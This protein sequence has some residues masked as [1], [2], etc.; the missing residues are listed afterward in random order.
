V[1]GFFE[2]VPKVYKK[3]KTDHKTDTPN[4]KKDSKRWIVRAQC[5]AVM[6]WR[7]LAAWTKALK[8][9]ND[10]SELC[11]LKISQEVGFSCS[12][13]IC[14]NHL[15]VPARFYPTQKFQ[16]LKFKSGRKNP[17]QK[18][19]KNSMEHENGFHFTINHCGK[20]CTFLISS[21]TSEG[22]TYKRE[23]VKIKPPDRC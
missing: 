15:E 21:Y 11:F 4:T 22:E 20:C 5:M 3:S 17:N 7:L 19:I 6:C 14:P 13:W 16:E 1:V 9:K 12:C 8:G 18:K 23:G 10:I 2:K